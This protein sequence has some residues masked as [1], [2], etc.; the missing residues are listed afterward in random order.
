MATV[1]KRDLVSA[2][3]DACDC[4]QNTAHDAVQALLDQIIEELSNGNRIELRDFGVFET[5][6][7]EAHTAHN[8][9]TRETVHVP[10]RAS[11]KFKPGRAMT[12]RVQA[13]VE[14][15]E[16]AAPPQREAA[17]EPEPEAGSESGAEPES[18]PGTPII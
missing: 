12:R 17:P 16:P 3:A 7:R 11:V 5:R 8:P 10:R 9:R 13:L 4:Q 1:T 6:T 18:P 2:I 15:P 14:E